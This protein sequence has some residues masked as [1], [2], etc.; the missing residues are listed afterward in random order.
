MYGERLR[1]KIYLPD[2]RV[3]FKLIEIL[4]GVNNI[5]VWVIDLGFTGIVGF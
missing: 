1:A 2:C 3:D 5:S 4:L